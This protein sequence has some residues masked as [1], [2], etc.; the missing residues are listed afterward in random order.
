MN[1]SFSGSELEDFLS[2]ENCLNFLS[3]SS[4]GA[5]LIRI[6]TLSSG[7]ESR[8]ILGDRGEGEGRSG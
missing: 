3:S 6:S 1:R 4:L 5:S 7:R 8:S 2:S